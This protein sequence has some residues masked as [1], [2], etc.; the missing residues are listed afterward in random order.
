[1]ETKN[2]FSI[3]KQK[4]HYLKIHL[5]L[6]L[7]KHFQIA[8]KVNIKKTRNCLSHAIDFAMVT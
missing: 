7:V 5:I 4:S 2:L 6:S 3:L 8:I 1:M